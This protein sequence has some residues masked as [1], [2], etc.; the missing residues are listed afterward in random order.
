[1]TIGHE[2]DG[3]PVAANVT[4][5]RAGPVESTVTRWDVPARRR[6]A[7]LFAGVWLV[8]LGKP[9]SDTMHADLPLAVQALGIGLTAIFAGVY[10]TGFAAVFAARG[11]RQMYPAR[12]L[13]RTRTAA[14]ILVAITLSMPW[15]AGPS[16]VA[17]VGF[18]IVLTA[19]ATPS[20]VAWPLM[21]VLVA[22]A[23]LLPVLL[24]DGGPSGSAAFST[25]VVAVLMIGARRIGAQEDEIERAR[26]ELAQLAVSQERARFARDL[27]DILGHS[28]TAITVKAELAGRLVDRDPTRAAVE[29]ADIERLAREALTDARS[30]VTGYRD[31]SLTGEI[32][33]ARAV[34]SAAGIDADLPGAVD[35]VPGATRELFAW[36]VREGVTNVLRHSGATRCAIRVTPTSVEVADN[37]TGGSWAAGNGLSGLRER[38]QAVGAELRAGA[39][40]GGGFRLRLATTPEQ[41]AGPVHRAE[42]ADAHRVSPPAVAER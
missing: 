34:L 2:A 6:W 3:V 5:M 21:G 37:G 24:R 9:I 28:L 40:A 33:T 19:F 39:A 7:V 35:E 25:G 12:L 16:A 23:S 20:R 22:W 15:I 4:A 26:D 27:H 30:T 36:A 14:A 29:I 13:R 10:L 41:P 11:R 18:T 17:F 8:Y 32:A 42:P 1:M 38:A 31:M